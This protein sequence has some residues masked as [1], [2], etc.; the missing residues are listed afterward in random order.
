MLVLKLAGHTLIDSV[1]Q[2]LVT[3]IFSCYLLASTLLSTLPCPSFNVFC[4]C[5][6][7]ST[8]YWSLFSQSEGFSRNERCAFSTWFQQTVNLIITCVPRML[9]VALI[10]VVYCVAVNKHNASCAICKVCKASRSQY[11]SQEEFLC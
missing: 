4:I 2:R 3:I 10:L 5:V 6:L 7:F 9:F 1:A 11:H 8:E